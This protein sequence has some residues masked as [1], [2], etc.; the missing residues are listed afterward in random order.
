MP[1]DNQLSTVAAA[2]KATS[3]PEYLVAEKIWW[4]RLAGHFLESRCVTGNQTEVQM[5]QS[6]T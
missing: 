1:S 4:H 3:Y 2:F 5:P 6:D